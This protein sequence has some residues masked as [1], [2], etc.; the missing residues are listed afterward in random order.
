MGNTASA[1]LCSRPQVPDHWTASHIASQ[2]GKTVI[3]TGA[4]SGIGYETALE[5]ARKGAT[6]VIACRSEARGKEAEKKITQ[7]L[8][9]TSTAG[10]ATFMQLDLS[11]LESVRTFAA[12]F[13]AAYDRLDLLINNAGVMAVPFAKTVDGNER[14]FATNHLGH[15]AL[16]A[17]LFPMLKQSTPSRVVNVSSIAHKNAKLKHFTAGSSIM[18]Q[19]D[20]G[21]NRWEVYA[22]SKLSNLLFTM[23]LTRRMNA[24]HVTGVTSVACHPGITVTNLMDSPGSE[25]SWHGRLFWRIG[26]FLSIGQHALAGALPTL[27]AAT[28]PDVE[29]NDYYG[30]NNR[31]ETWGPPTRVQMID[32]AHDKGAAQNLWDESERLAKLKFDV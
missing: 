22:E 2:K 4:N 30:P 31:F 1:Q 5:L 20:K 32:A 6:V 13:K 21:F 16:T 23:E 19:S 18:R 24:Q 29:S 10:R 3:V 11:S 27:Y 9:T 15:F 12:A 7:A 26:R 17:T 28:G 25:G 8:E 14:Q